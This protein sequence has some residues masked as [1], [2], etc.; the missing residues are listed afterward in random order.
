MRVVI[1]CS[2]GA[3]DAGASWINDEEAASA[4]LH[5]E[6]P[7]L[8]TSPTDASPS[9]GTLLVARIVRLHIY[10]H[11]LTPVVPEVE[12]RR[13]SGSRRGNAIM[14]REESGIGNM[15]SPPPPSRWCLGDRDHRPWPGVA[16]IGTGSNNR[17]TEVRQHA[18]LCVTMRASELPSYLSN[19]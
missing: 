12:R 6:S 14:R 19:M 1:I 13:W 16:C 10:Y 17:L 9:N 11:A 3:P 2:L 4:D 7:T 18:T 8:T 15:T 5:Q